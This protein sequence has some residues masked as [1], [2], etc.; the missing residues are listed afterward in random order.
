MPKTFELFEIKK[1]YSPHLFNTLSNQNYVGAIPALE[2]YGP[3]N[4][5]EKK[6]HDLILWHT[7][8]SNKGCVFDIQKKIIQYCV[9]NVEILTGACLKFRQLM[10]H[11][12]NIC[13]FTDSCL[14][15]GACNTIGLTPKKSYK[16]KDNQSKLAI[17]WLM[18]Q[19]CQRGINILHAAPRSRRGL[20]KSRWF[21]Y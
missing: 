9:S 16:Y 15:T 3:D 20:G 8:L 18:W 12:G 5:K 17:E 2:Y 21:L 11:K 4:I 19:E 7:E 10:L 6:R 1:G 13:L 14:H